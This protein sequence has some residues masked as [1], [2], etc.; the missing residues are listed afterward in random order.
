MKE[1]IIF[2]GVLD[3]GYKSDFAGRQSIARARRKAAYLSGYDRC[4]YG[5]WTE[6]EL[7]HIAIGNQIFENSGPGYVKSDFPYMSD[8]KNSG[9]MIDKDDNK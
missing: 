2:V 8:M 1:P 4:V 7:T 3:E 5:I 9:D 6:E